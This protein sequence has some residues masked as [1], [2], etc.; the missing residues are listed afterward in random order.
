NIIQ[1]FAFTGYQEDEVSGLKFAQARYYKA[2]T[3]RFQS[4]DNVKGFIISPFTLNHY[5]YCWENP[6]NLVDNDGNLPTIIGGALI[7]GAIG[8]AGDVISQAV[9]GK[10]IMEI[11][12][13]HAAVTGLKGAAV[14]AAIGAGVGAVAAITQTAVGGSTGVAMAASMTKGAAVCGTMSAVMETGTEIVTNED[15][16]INVGQI[17]VAGVGGAIAGLITGSG[18]G[19]AASSCLNAVNAAVVSIVNDIQKGES[20]KKIIYDAC[21]SGI[22]GGA[23]GFI[24]GDGAAKDAYDVGEHLYLFKANGKYV[25]GQAKKINILHHFVDGAKYI[26]AQ[27]ARGL[28]IAAGT[29][30]IGSPLV[31]VAS[32]LYNDSPK[33]ECGE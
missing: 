12:Y 13:G 24:G 23:A 30:L 26:S 19:R 4:E 3:G 20:T 7:G 28:V 11:D 9:S 25:L 32:N 18:I 2:E 10:N 8:F 33:E 27:L 31:T 6:V 29:T 14:G 17:G 15:H 1:P 16:S 5:G 22:I 21:V